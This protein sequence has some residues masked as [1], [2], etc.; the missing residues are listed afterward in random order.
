[1]Q[2]RYPCCSGLAAHKQL[3]VACLTTVDASGERRKET[4]QFTPRTRDI[5]ALAEWLARGLYACRHGVNRG[6]VATDVEPAGRAVRA[7]A[8]KRPSHQSGPPAARPTS[9]R[10]SGSL[11]CFS[12]DWCAAISP[13]PS[14]TP[15]ARAH[16]LPHDVLGRARS[17]RQPAPESPGGDQ[18]QIERGGDQHPGPLCPRAAHGAACRGARSAGLSQRSARETPRETGATR[19]GAGGA[20]SG[21]APLCADQPVGAYRMLGGA[22]RPVRRDHRAVPRADRE[23]TAGGRRMPDACRSR[24]RGR[25]SGPDTARRPDTRTHWFPR[26]RQP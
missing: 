12:M 26:R 13:A 15:A 23:C 1:M 14:P 24:S 17:G 19:G 8:G 2:V 9:R 11:S 7:P 6:V 3:L 10:P 21:A 4:R 18:P 25:R 20:D 5:L 16:S 22:R